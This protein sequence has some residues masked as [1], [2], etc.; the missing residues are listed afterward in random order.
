MTTVV[1]LS[2]HEASHAM[3]EQLTE[4]LGQFEFLQFKGTYGKFSGKAE[5]ISFVESFKDAEGIETS[6]SQTIPADSIIVAVA[7]PQLQIEILNAIRFAGGAAILLQPLTNR[8]V[9]EEG[10]ATFVYTGLNQVHK[11]EFMTSLFAGE[12]VATALNR[13]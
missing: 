1:F 4:K 11:I 12:M 3:M 6:V 7:P 5:G 10:K 8:V 13:R 9:D 2:R